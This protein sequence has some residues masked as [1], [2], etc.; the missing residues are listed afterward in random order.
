VSERWLPDDFPDD[1][2][3]G[4]VAAEAEQV[5]LMPAIQALDRVVEAA[6]DILAGLWRQW[7][8]NA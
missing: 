2:F 8:I 4:A 7:I 1:T 6:L 3:S 5:E